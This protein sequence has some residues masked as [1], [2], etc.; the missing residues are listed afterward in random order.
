MVQRLTIQN[1]AYNV[2]DTKL[3]IIVE[4]GK[5]SKDSLREFGERFSCADMIRELTGRL[6][7][8]R[9]YCIEI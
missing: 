8:A 5:I 9:D 7:K 4:S 3:G 2:F 6:L 1:V